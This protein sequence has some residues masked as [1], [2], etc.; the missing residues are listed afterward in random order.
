MAKM[1]P[2]VQEAEVRQYDLEASQTF[3]YGAVV[4]LDGS[5]EIVEAGADPAT[6]LGIALKEGDE[7]LPFDDKVLV[8]LAEGDG[9][10]WMD[11]DDDPV[12]SDVDQEYGIAKDGDGVWHVDGTDTSATRVYV[13]DVDLDRNRYL[14]KFLEANRQVSA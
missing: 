9:Q 11:G 7:A 8:A 1:V 14:V 13:I 5:Q 4:L 2:V 6:I 3:G 10:F 12:A